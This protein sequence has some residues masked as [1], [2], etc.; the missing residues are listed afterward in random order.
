MRVGVGARARARARVRARAWVRV[1]VRVG[2]RV[3]A[4]VRVRRLAL[5]PAGW[6]HTVAASTNYG[7]RVS[8]LDLLPRLHHT[9][10]AA[11]AYVIQSSNPGQPDPVPGGSSSATA[12]RTRLPLG[13]EYKWCL[14]ALIYV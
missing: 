9:L 14:P 10:R 5:W 2:V 1:R 8:L 11:A 4:W 6:A 3:R 7:C 13:S 12:S